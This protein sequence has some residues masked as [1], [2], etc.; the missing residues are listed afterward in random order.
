MK[1][2]PQKHHRRSIRLKG[3]DYS[4][5]GAYFFTIVAWQRES[6]F[7]EVVDGKMKLI[8]MDTLSAMHG[9]T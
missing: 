9:L 6:L 3:Y 7:G 5:A 8:A 2:D 4:S 1:F